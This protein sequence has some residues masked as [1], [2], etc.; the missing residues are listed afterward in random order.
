MCLLVPTLN[1]VKLEDD[2]FPCHYPYHLHGSIHTHKNNWY[3]SCHLRQCRSLFFGFLDTSRFWIFSF[4]SRSPDE[5]TVLTNVFSFNWV[6]HWGPK[7]CFA[8]FVL[9][10]SEDTGEDKDTDYRA[11][12]AHFMFLYHVRKEKLDPTIE[13]FF[14]LITGCLEIPGM[15]VLQFD[16]TLL[17]LAFDRRYAPIF[18]VQWIPPTKYKNF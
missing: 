18:A 9:V 3:A 2:F 14:I 6:T 17:L 15:D 13:S 1:C 11:K 8:F 12:S 5:H 10:N 4:Y 16:L 7:F